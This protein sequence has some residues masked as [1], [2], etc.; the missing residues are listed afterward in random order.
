[1]QPFD[2]TRQVTEALQIARCTARLSEDRKRRGLPLLGGLHQSS[3][4]QAPQ[5]AHRQVRSRG[6]GRRRAP[7]GAQGRSR[8]QPRTP[9]AELRG[10]FNRRSRGS[11]CA[12]APVRPGAVRKAPQRIPPAPNPA[13][14]PRAAGGA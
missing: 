14:A 5:V 11:R 3:P 6:K 10:H 9:Q 8:F 4:P 13:P 2:L 12:A 7:A 1:M